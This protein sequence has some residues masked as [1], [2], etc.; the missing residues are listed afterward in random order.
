MKELTGWLLDIYPE[1]LGGVTL[2]LVGQDGQRYRLQQPFPVTFYAAGPSARLRHL[3]RYL[4]TQSASLTL[5]RTERRDLFADK[6]IPVLAIQLGNPAAQPA[7]FQQISVAYPDLTYFDADIP[8]AGT[9]DA[10]PGYTLEA[11]P[12]PAALTHPVL[13][14]GC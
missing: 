11:R 4:Q 7:L 1:T 5:S 12:A 2:W 8:L 10:M 13:R 9:P 3:W 14:A 6:M